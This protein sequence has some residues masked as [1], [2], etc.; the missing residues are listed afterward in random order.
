MKAVTATIGQTALLLVLGAAIGVGVNTVRGKDQIDLRRN[1]FPPPT[2][3][4]TPA[5]QPVQKSEFHELTLDEVV[6]V[7]DDAKVA[8]GEYVFV[9]ARADGPFREG[10]IPRAVQCDYYRSENYLPSVL[11]EVAGAE[12]VI[13]YCNGG[14]CEDSLLVCREFLS[15]GVSLERVFLFRGGWQEWK[16]AGMPFEQSER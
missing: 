1:Y 9:D 6:K 3:A 10:H 14:E 5:T 13:V 11:T 2:T 15:L 4:P 12:K 7:F 8:T 16:D